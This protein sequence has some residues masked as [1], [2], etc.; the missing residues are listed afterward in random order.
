VERGLPDR[1]QSLSLLFF[2]SFFFFSPH[3]RLAFPGSLLYQ[4][5][6]MQFWLEDLGSVQSVDT[7]PT[8]AY[9]DALFAN[10]SPHRSF[11]F[12]MAGTANQ[13]HAQ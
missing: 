11:K 2:F 5:S 12:S 1:K 8:S 3:A 10:A 13:Y 6:A 9:P 7:E 4:I